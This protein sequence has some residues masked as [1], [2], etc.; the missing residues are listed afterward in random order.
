MEQWTRGDFLKSSLAIIAGLAAPTWLSEDE[1][2]EMV[3]TVTG[4]KPAT[5][6][7]FTLTHEHIMVDFIG[8]KEVTLDRYDKEAVFNTALP[9][10]QRVKKAGCKTFIECTPAYLGRDVTLFQRLS[11]ASGLNIIT[12]TGYY[13]ASKEKYFP[14]H[15]YTESADQLA[16]RWIAEF[17][18]G[19]D[20]MD[21]KPGFIKCGTDK[22]PLSPAVRKT[23]TAAAITNRST[24]LPIGVHTGDGKAAMEQLDIL[25]KEQVPAS[26]WI[27]IHAQNEAD[28]SY[29]FTAARKGGWVSFD[30]YHP[31]ATD[32]YIQFLHDM[33]KSHLLN[34]V[35]ISHDA[36]WYHVGEPEGGDY[37][38][39]NDIFDHLLPA[40]KK[41]GFS[42]SDIKLL[43]NT[44]PAVAFA[45]RSPA[46]AKR[47]KKII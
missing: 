27:W 9:I 42:A 11:I 33:K 25:Q 22:A 29:H 14:D 44:N 37:R 47:I 36:G 32:A 7:G 34:K 20:G 31:N 23:I 17:Q 5:S 30:G 16:A 13:G 3:M 43:F 4:K 2:N 19:I 8:A 6:L 39:Y 35:L 10:L 12:N 45:L 15:V 1:N 24:G 28:R 21:V 38:P 18:H 46:N 40:M 26:A 41:S